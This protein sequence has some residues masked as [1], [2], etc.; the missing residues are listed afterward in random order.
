M[1][2]FNYHNVSSSDDPGIDS[3]SYQCYTVDRGINSSQTVQFLIEGHQD[4]FI[5]MSQCYLKTTFRVVDAN[6]EILP[7]PAGD[8]PLYKGVFPT[9]DYGNM[10]WS[11]V[12]VSINNTPLPPGNDYAYTAHITDLVGANPDAR[13]QVKGYLAGFGQPKYLS[14]KTEH[15]LPGT[16]L[17]DKESVRGSKPITIFSR[18]YSDFMM[19]CSQFLP[20]RMPLCISLTRSKDPFVLGSDEEAPQSY[21]VDIMSVSLFVKRAYLNP[22]ARS[23]VESGLAS[24]GQLQYQRLHTVVYPCAQGSRSWNWHNC[25]GSIV[26]RRV[27]VALV[28]QEAYFGSYK[29]CSAYLESAGIA[30]VRFCLDGR[31]IMPEPYRTSFFYKDNGQLDEAKSDAKS[32]FAGLSRV[33]GN[34]VYANQFLGFRYTYFLDG[35][36]LFAVAM[37]NAD[38]SKPGSGS[39]DVHMDFQ[40]PTKEAMMVIMVGEYPRTIAFDGQRNLTY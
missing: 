21:R 17:L 30:S 19:T 27:F 26:P 36:T 24:G 15:S 32:A 23:L 13:D 11:Q 29:R 34:F 33:I 14:S 6:G 12:G 38:G 10:L 25:F 22:P 3:S 8:N 16:Y 40:Q 31:E 35:S 18:I 39:F 37:D 4:S 9:E 7:E 2:Q 20:T 5:D 28:S 1:E